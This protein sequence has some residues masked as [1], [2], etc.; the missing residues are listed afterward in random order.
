MTVSA[1]LS[2]VSDN[3]TTSA[4]SKVHHLDQRHRKELYEKRGLDRRWCEV[5]CQSVTAEKASFH[6]GY[7]SHSEG[8]WLQGANYQ[9][10]F[11]P[12]NPWKTKE[13]SKAPK[14]RSPLG[15]YDAM[16]PIHPD[17]L[18]Y[19]SDL[20]AVKQDCY[21]INGHPCVLITEGFIKAIAGC[22]S[23]IITVGLLGVEMGLTPASADPQGKRYLVPALEKLASAGFGF[24][25]AF[26]ADSA[27]N[28]NVI[29]AQRKLA[30]Q[31][32]KFE[33]PQY[34]ITGLWAVTEGKGMDDYIKNNGADKF[35]REVLGKAIDIS[36]WEK[37]F[38]QPEPGSRRP[39]AALTAEEIAQKYQDRLFW[40]V[41]ES[42]WY[43]YEAEA[44]GMWAE[45]SDVVIGSAILAELEVKLGLT[46]GSAYLY[47][48]MKILKHKLVRRK[49][50]QRDDLI[51]LIDGVLDKK[52]LQM[53]PHSPDYNLTW[54]VPIRWADRAIGCEPIKA[55][56]LEIMQGD[57]TL[58]EVLRGII[59]CALFSRYNYQRYLES[60]GP[61]G[62]GKGTFFRLITALIGEKNTFITTLK[63]LEEN[64]FEAG[65]AA[66]AKLVLITEAEKFGGDVN[67]LK[68]MVGED[69]V[70]TEIK[71]KQQRV[72]EAEKFKGIILVSANETVQ[73]ADYTSGLERRRLPVP[74]NH[75]TPPDKRRD[76]LKEFEPYMAGLLFWALT[77]PEEEVR[78]LILNT[79][80]SVPSLSRAYY[81]S[82]CDTNPLADWLDNKIIHD[83][84]AKTYVG[85]DD[86]NKINSWLY[87]NYA[88]YTRAIN[89]RVIGQ[90]RFSNLLEDLCCSQ[91]KL[92][93][94]KRG[95]DR[96]GSYFEGLK[97][98]DE[99]DTAPRP[100]T[101]A[102]VMEQI[103]HFSK[104]VMAET[105]GSDGCDGCYEKNGTV[106]IAEELISDEIENEKLLAE[107]SLLIEES[108]TEQETQSQI[109]SQ[110][111]Q[112]ENTIRHNPSPA[113]TAITYK[114]INENKSST[115]TTIESAEL[116]IGVGR[117]AN[118]YGECVEIV[119]W[120]N[121]G[122][123]VQ[124]QF[125]NGR[126]QMVKRG[127]L[128]A[129]CD[130]S[131]TS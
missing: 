90:R 108:I 97:F 88:S 8:I 104:N 41:K 84:R 15:D 62:T 18:R 94:V 117:N 76:L 32:A 91:L 86:A 87:A 64:R 29:M 2:Q 72:G 33:V 35:K 13:D 77:M 122:S 112:P 44:P 69:A 49:F 12:D 14:Y 65:A 128:K 127:S 109:D 45:E 1:E 27:T 23:D 19:W 70:R 9:G 106:N 3:R 79:K 74:F 58:V 115:S 96:Y 67:I 43:A 101:G 105:L 55:W 71:G 34:S 68:A 5:N 119:G 98:R 124:I 92:P 99:Y 38:H 78:E 24:I 61:G 25:H 93:G 111:P 83:P 116:I 129:W 82:L 46:F 123:K 73:N 47:D 75:Q 42:A 110:P 131:K 28:K 20:E 22:M 95:R 4:T 53:L 48:V 7:P 10:Q 36:S 57:S 26:D 31:L 114:A 120:E 66:K 54:S 39:S 81:E 118:Y 102:N 52:T 89:S 125:P 17:N 40:H 16:L 51:P 80:N 85:V 60:I 59:N 6:L 107:E 103:S 63:Q 130:L 11:R 100:I 30:N 126:F 21:Q 121:Y 50:E 37:Q 113:S 56:M